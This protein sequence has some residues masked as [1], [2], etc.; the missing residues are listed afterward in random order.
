MHYQT[1]H[2]HEPENENVVLYDSQ[3]KDEWFMCDKSALAISEAAE[4]RQR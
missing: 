2:D 4:K 1:T 3:F